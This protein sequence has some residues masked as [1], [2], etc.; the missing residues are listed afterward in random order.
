MNEP[1]SEKSFKRHV[2]YK[3]R[4]G[5]ILA[6]NP[7]FEDIKLKYVEA[8]GKN[9]S[10]VN[11]I[12]NVV[13][14]FL[15][16]GEKKYGSLILDDATGQIAVK[17]F[18]DAV[19]EIE[20]IQQGDTLL[21]IGLLRS[22][23]NQLYITS[24]IIKKKEPEYLLIRKLEIEAEQKPLLS[25]EK[26]AALKDNILTMIK[27]SEEN[28]GVDVEKIILELNELPANIN[29][30]IRRLL[31]DGLIYEPRPGKLRYLG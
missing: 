18:G 16:E 27:N 17:F 31:E 8:D 29:K 13:D 30:E 1:M 15:Q 24:E 6:G 3:L 21:V 9:V 19:K 26:V 2:A 28:G 7:V 5:Q 20:G 4:I 10:R 25:R 23:Q 22:W 11:L 14:K 12:A